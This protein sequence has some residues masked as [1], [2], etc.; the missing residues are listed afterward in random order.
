[1]KK[2][3]WYNNKQKGFTLVELMVALTLFVVV[4]MAAVSSLFSV[5]NAS[6]K[7]QAMRSV[8]DNL[9]FAM[10]SMSRTIRTGNL[11][12]CGGTKNG[13]YPN[14]GGTYNCVFG[15]DAPGEQLLVHSTLGSDQLIEYRWGTNPDNGHGQI[16]KRTQDINGNWPDNWL[17]LTAPEIDVQKLS[18]Y[19]DGADTTDTSQPNVILFVQGIAAAD[20]DNVSPFAVQTYISQRAI[21]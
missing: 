19:V 21:E 9:N 13:A 17:S 15:V 18:F 7:V 14:A 2:K 8:L 1:M 11:V 6:R 20:A 3:Q 4:V 10:E 12:V 16:E 5:N